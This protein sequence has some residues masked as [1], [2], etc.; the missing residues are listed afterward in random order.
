MKYAFLTY[1]HS[2]EVDSPEGW[3][4]RTKVY[5][6]VLYH[7]SKANTVINIKQ[8]NY[9]GECLHNGVHYH[10]VNFGKK[11]TY[12][13]VKLN[14]YV[15]KIKPDVVFVQGLHNPAQV[16]QL[17]LILGKATKIIVQ[18]HAEQPLT[19][20]KK[21]LQLMAGNCINAC[22]FASHAMGMDWVK[23][24][25]LPKRLKIHEVMEVSS[26]FYPVEKKLATEKTGVAGNPVFLWVGRLN[27]NKDPLNVAKAFLKFAIINPAARLYM[28]YQTDELLS[29]L[30]ELLEDINKSPIVMVGEVAHDKLLYWFNS[31]DFII[32]G[33]HYEGSGT[34]ICE[35][36][37]CGCIP[38]VTDIPAF[39]AITDNGNC[40]LLYEAGKEEA[41]L[42]AL[43]QTNNLNLPEKR[44]NSLAYFN[45]HLSFDAIAQKIQ[46]IADSL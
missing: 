44:N 20:T 40:G 12:F 35:A 31:A 30:N 39:R 19:G 17:R 13:P 2:L 23:K 46:A 32:S 22:L 8:I 21:Y 37:S 10:F 7:L 9:E 25:N 6:A 38:I 34:A 42:S 1:N 18:N 3:Y 41:L 14:L 45:K 16:I 33:S 29:A 36:M 11:K 27:E 5:A 4:K 15:K 26:A 24:G 28:I 43:L